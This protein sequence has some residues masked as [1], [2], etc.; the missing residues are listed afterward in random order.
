MSVRQRERQQLLARRKLV[1]RN[2]LKNT[3]NLFIGI[4]GQHVGVL[5]RRGGTHAFI[6]GADWLFGEYA[7]PISLTMPLTKKSTLVI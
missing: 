5:E 1:A 6:Y 3:Y 4:N 7:H 2:D